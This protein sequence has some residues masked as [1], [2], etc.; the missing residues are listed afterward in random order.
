[1]HNKAE[2]TTLQTV[3]D[4]FNENKLQDLVSILSRRH[5]LN[6]C[7]LCLGYVFHF[8]Q[9]AGILTTTVAAGYD[10]RFLIWVGVGLNLLASL[11]NVYEKTNSET[12]KRLMKDLKAIKNNTYID[13][14]ELTIPSD[15][16]TT[17]TTTSEPQPQ[18]QPRQQQEPS[19]EPRPP[20]RE[21]DPV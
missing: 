14:E 9:A 1:M 15:K 19:V 5:C 18:P 10:E 12:M 13:E 2:K 16:P 6:R 20:D 21:D 11:I 7:N 3:D 17:V 8:V 4:V